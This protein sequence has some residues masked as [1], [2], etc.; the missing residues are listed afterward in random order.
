VRRSASWLI[1]LPVAVIACFSSLAKAEPQAGLNAVGYVFEP[2]QLPTRSDALYPSCGSELENNINRNFN[3]EPFQD[4]PNDFFM[5]HY[6]GFIAIPENSSV[7]FMVAA[8]DGGTVNIGGYQFGTWNLKGCSWSQPITLPVMQGIYPLDGWFFEWGGGTCFMLA[9]NINDAGWEI[10]PEWAFTTT[11]TPTTTTSTTTVLETTV[12]ATTTTSTTVQETS[13][14]STVQTPATTE[15]TETSTTVALTTSTVVGTST[16]TTTEPEPVTVS[17][18]TTTTEPAATTSSQPPIVD[19]SPAPTQT[20]PPDTVPPTTTEPELVEIVPEVLPEES[21]EQLETPAVDQ[22]MQPLEDTLSPVVDDA[23]VTALPS[24]SLPDASETVPAENVPTQL[25]SSLEAGEQP[26]PEQALVMATSSEVL[27]VAT[28]EQVAEIFEAL[29]VAELT[30][31]QI[32]ALVEAVQDA[33]AEVRE[34][35]EDSIN[36]F[37]EGFDDYVPLGSTIPVAVRRT[38][39]AVSA[40]LTMMP[41]PVVGSRAGTK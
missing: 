17:Q 12:P 1:F 37:G 3:G 28:A 36:I 21:P 38:L 24:E 35:F 2:T 6:S 30:D 14:T 7:E 20:I 22:D 26:T 19:M 32:A 4:C 41:V 39:V 9:W 5:V 27:S 15:I 13:T 18:T 8:D 40:V 11:S 10:V 29:D 31:T 34:A 33:P 23:I 25:F 16:T